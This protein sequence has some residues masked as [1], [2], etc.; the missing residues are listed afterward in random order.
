MNVLLVDNSSDTFA[1]LQ[2]VVMQAGH[3]VTSISYREIPLYPAD[4]YQLVILSGGWWYDDEVELLT[5]YAEELELIRTC[6]VPLL[7]I[8]IGMQLMHV[9]LD[10]AVPLLDV[11]QSGRKDITA[12]ERGIRAGLPPR[13]QVHKNHTR[14]IIEADPLFEVLAS[15]PGHIE[16]MQH[17]ERPMLG[18]QFHP[19]VGELDEC[20]NT[21]GMLLGLIIFETQEQKE[22][23]L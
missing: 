16:I 6:P 7:G 8:C 5:Q 3:S 2:E 21:L 20:V 18:V 4:A 12:T 17:R 23:K 15:S 9:A 10:R 13:M 11:P 22:G 19:E 14:G 1:E